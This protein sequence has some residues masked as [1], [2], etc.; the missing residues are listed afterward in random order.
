MMQLK[1]SVAPSRQPRQEPAPA[2]PVRLKGRMTPRGYEPEN[3]AW[4]ALLTFPDKRLGKRADGSARLAGIDPLKLPL[5][6]LRKAG[7]PNR[8]TR[9]LVRALGNPSNQHASNEVGDPMEA[10]GRVTG[11]S[12]LPE[13]C[14]ACAGDAVARRRCAT[15]NC[16]FW[17]YRM[18]KN[19]HNPQRS[20]KTGFAIKKGR[21]GS[22][23]EDEPVA[24]GRILSDAL[25]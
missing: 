11:Y 4:T 18:G 17:A 3:E 7:H 6:T 2:A 23:I 19:P 24:A 13:Y 12:D 14:N 16:P 20:A 21:A 5:D 25:H 22:Q 1:S 8:S 10:L 15:I 9:D